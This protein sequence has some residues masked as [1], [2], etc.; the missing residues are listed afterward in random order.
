MKIY[1]L[2]IIFCFLNV[3]ICDV[4]GV[5]QQ[6]LQEAFTSSLKFINNFHQSEFT[7]PEY[8]KFSN[9]KLNLQQLYSNNV[10]FR[11]DEYGLL[12]IKFVNLKISISGN[13][14][15]GGGFL[16]ILFSG[17]FTV[18]LTNF[19]WEHTVAVSSSKNSGKYNINSK[20]IS[21]SDIYY[22][23]RFKLKPHIVKIGDTSNPIKK[24]FENNFKKFN[25]NNFKEYMKKIIKS[26][27]NS[28]ENN[29]NKV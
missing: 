18:D 26:I 25:L 24:E 10:Q 21:E 2:L 15:F 12:H 29:L 27:F 17:P 3:I 4:E 14:K 20:Y 16:N 13:F 23:S 6:S 1:S 11:F 5:N 28:L 22:I 19:I 8:E 7:I 9:L